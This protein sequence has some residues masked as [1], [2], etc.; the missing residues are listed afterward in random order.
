MASGYFERPG[1]PLVALVGHRRRREAERRHDEAQHPVVLRQ[2][3]DRVHRRPRHQAVVAG[4]AL[5]VRARHGADQPV[6]GS[7]A[8]P[9]ERRVARAVRAHAVDD[10]DALV[11]R[12]GEHLRDHLGRVLQVGVEGHDVVA[13]GA[14]QARGD[15]RLVTGVGAQPDHAELGPLAPDPL[16]HHGRRVGAAVV[17]GHH[18]VGGLERVGHG[19]QTRDEQGQDVFLVVDGDDDAQLGRH[20]TSLRAGGLL[21]GRS[22]R[23]RPDVARRVTGTSPTGRRDRPAR[24]EGPPKYEFEGP[25]VTALPT[26]D[27]RPGCHGFGGAPRHRGGG[28][29]PSGRAPPGRPD[30]FLPITDPRAA[31]EPAAAWPLR[32]WRRRRAGPRPAVRL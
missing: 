27:Q 1:G 16:Q 17:D 21:A 29:P 12:C 15:G 30:G 13:P 6:E 4:V 19:P 3:V 8:E 11:A 22:W 28:G 24:G 14:G 25:S 32:R 23:A 9:L 26:G 2:G 20:A 7:G 31:G 5:G 10:V 18:L